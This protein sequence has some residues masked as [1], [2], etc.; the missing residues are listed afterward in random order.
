MRDDSV[1]EHRLAEVNDVV[2]DDVDT[3]VDELFDRAHEDRLGG[4][5]GVEVQLS[6]G[7]EVVDQLGHAAPLVDAVEADAGQIVGFGDDMNEVRQLFGAATVCAEG[8]L[9]ALT[10]EAAGRPIGEG[11]RDHSDANAVARH[12]EGLPS[13]GGADREICLRQNLS[14]GGPGAVVGMDRGHLG[15][16]RQRR[17]AV[18]PQNPRIRAW[19]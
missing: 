12:V 18:V 3:A 6:A 9:T 13:L 5:R 1:L 14:A 19:R 17:Q 11:V 10:G 16:S 4:E 15:N 7:S 2:D 8:P